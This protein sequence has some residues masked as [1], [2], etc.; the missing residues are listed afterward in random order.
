MQASDLDNGTD[1]MDARLEVRLFGPMRVSICGAPMPRLRSRKGLWLLALLA[2]RDG[3]DVDRGWIAGTLWPESDEA[4][5]RGR[6][7]YRNG[8]RPWY[9][10]PAHLEL[11]AYR[12]RGFAAGH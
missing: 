12:E 6:S 2:L 9:R 3:R 11:P 4:R 10:L 1:G 8:S 5:S 7:T